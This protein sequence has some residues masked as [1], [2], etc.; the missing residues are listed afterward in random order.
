M[1]NDKGGMNPS[2][3]DTAPLVALEGRLRR[4]PFVVTLGVRPNYSDYSAEEKRL[5]QQAAKIYYPS[6][7]Y[8]E[9]LDA[10]GKRT[11]PSY[12]TYKIA[13]DKIKQT[14]LFQMAGI[15]HPRTRVFFGKR[16]KRQIRDYFKLP[17][18]AKVARGSA[19]GRGVFLIRTPGE[20]EHYCQ[21]HSPAYIQEYLSIDKDIRVVVIGRKAVHAYWRV[22]PEGEFRTNVAQGGEIDLSPVPQEAI[23]LAEQ[24]AT[25]CHLDDVGF[26]ICHHQGNFMVLEANMKY[27]R[28]GFRQYG[29]D[30]EKMMERL[31][32]DG[33]I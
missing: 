10:I 21:N 11:F 23:R 17:L 5:I 33:E 19:L 3:I 32:A 24:A 15:P 20:L 13:Q 1:P 7:F 8:A 16:Q 31:I 30:F 26:D 9:L 29:I 6:T 25:L 28:E 4:C 14:A 2:N 12:H 22:A 27:G 18:V